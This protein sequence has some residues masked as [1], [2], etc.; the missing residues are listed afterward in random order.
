MMVVIPPQQS[1]SSA[2]AN[3]FQHCRKMTRDG[4]N[5]ANA[6]QSGRELVAAGDGLNAMCT[7]LRRRLRLSRFGRLG[8]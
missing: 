1:D 6:A 4:R 8:R 3:G 7:V 2:G 5:R